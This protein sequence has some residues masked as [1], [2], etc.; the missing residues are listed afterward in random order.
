MPAEI[1]EK[2]LD[3]VRE[4]GAPVD[5]LTGMPFNGCESRHVLR[6]PRQATFHP[7]KYLAG[8]AKACQENG[9][10]F[11]RAVRL[12][13]SARKRASSRLRRAGQSTRSSPPTRRSPTACAVCPSCPA[14][15]SRSPDNAATTSPPR[16]PQRQSARP[17][18][19]NSHPSIPPRQPASAGRW[20]GSDHQMLASNPASILMMWTPPH[21]PATM[22]PMG[23]PKRE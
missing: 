16:T 8:V 20:K 5:R 12:K 4:V 7:L 18:S 13:K 15:Q 9:V 19:G 6:Y 23:R 17:S 3:A 14:R 21:R 11:L 1:I 2:E 10:T 22:M